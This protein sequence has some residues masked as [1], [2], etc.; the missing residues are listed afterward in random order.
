[1][2]KDKKQMV[3]KDH[4]SRSWLLYLNT[5]ALVIKCCSRARTRRF[6]HN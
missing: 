5:D 3:H 2:T 4:H 6:M 1:M